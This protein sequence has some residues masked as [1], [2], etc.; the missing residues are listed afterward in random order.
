MCGPTARPRS[1]GGGRYAEAEPELRAVVE[2]M[3]SVNDIDG[4]TDG[5][6]LIGEVLV[7]QGR[8]GEAAA[9]W[10]EAADI[11]RSRNDPRADVVAARVAALG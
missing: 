3:R 2:F 1:P 9:A 5:L 11:H 4:V 10:Q 8:V 7:G 6:G